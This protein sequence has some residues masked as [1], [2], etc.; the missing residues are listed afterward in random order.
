[1]QL[2]VHR[3]IGHILKKIN[4]LFSSVMFISL[5]HVLFAILKTFCWI[6]CVFGALFARILCSLYAKMMQ[7]TKHVIYKG[8]S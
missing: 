6:V 5:K 3:S 1:M 2:L 8:H 7:K 4:K